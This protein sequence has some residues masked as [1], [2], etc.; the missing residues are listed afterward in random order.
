MP[1][2]PAVRALRAAGVEFTPHF[3][4]Y[5]DRGGT[6]ASSCTL[7]I[8]EHAVVKTLIMQDD[9]ARAERT[10]CG[11]WSIMALGSPCPANLHPPNRPS[12]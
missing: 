9:A 11:G 6:A 8:D 4:D 10:R 3:Y 12:A 7:G 1:S 2:T 5:E